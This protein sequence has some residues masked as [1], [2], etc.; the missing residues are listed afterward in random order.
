MNEL[1][2]IEENKKLKEWIN[3]LAEFLFNNYYRMTYV[4]ELQY[5]RRKKDIIRSICI[6]GEE[7]N[8]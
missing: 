1:D 2:I 5:E 8:V 3:K 7:E 6:E 4:D